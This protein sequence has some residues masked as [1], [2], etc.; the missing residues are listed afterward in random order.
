MQLIR[1]LLCKTYLRK[2]DL[3]VSDILHT[4]VDIKEG[5]VIVD[6]GWLITLYYRKNFFGIAH[7]GNPEAFHL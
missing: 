7:L 6:V 5:A 4:I 1:Y 2:K 3:V